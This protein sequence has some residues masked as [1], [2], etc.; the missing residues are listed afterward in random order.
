VSGVET[1]RQKAIEQVLAR[2]RSSAPQTGGAYL[3]SYTG[4][5]YGRWANRG[6]GIALTL[7]QRTQARTGETGADFL[8]RVADLVRAQ[9]DEYRRNEADEDGACSGALDAAVWAITSV[10]PKA[11][12]DTREAEPSCEAQSGE[13]MWEVWY[14]DT[15][16]RECPLSVDASGRG[17]TKGLMELWARFLF[18][19]VRPNGSRG[20][21]SFHLRWKELYIDIG[22]DRVGATRLREWVFGAKKRTAVGY[23]DAGDA[24][25]LSEI[26]RIHA[27][28]L[29]GDGSS[30]QILAA[31]AASANRMDFEARLSALEA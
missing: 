2:K 20:F 28:L 6:F 24:A 22:G 3:T 13:A 23:V 31:A 11:P 21:S 16:D 27:A 9:R 30:E 8:R 5:N 25:L 4:Y 12:P 15:F 7:L 10:L 29:P 26:A 14:R 19:T 18:E 1:L 17:L